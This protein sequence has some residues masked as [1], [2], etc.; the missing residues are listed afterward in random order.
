MNV[1]TDSLYLVVNFNSSIE[2]YYPD[3]IVNDFRVRL[4][5]PLTLCNGFW[6]VALCEIHIVNILLDPVLTDD[7]PI[8]LQVEFD[9]C[10][11]ILVDGNPSRALRLIPYEINLR[12]IFTCPFYV[13]VQT[14][15]IDSCHISVKAVSTKGIQIQHLNNS[16]I[17]CTLHFKK[18]H[19]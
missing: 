11:G 7:V 18:V 14:G 15:Y 17:T 2:D 5:N 16:C 10:E 3:N 13:P 1:P 9:S 19:Q 6:K 4:N 8:F 12:T